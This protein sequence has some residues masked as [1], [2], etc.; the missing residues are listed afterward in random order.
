MIQHGSDQA[1][2][3]LR[4]LPQPAPLAAAVWQKVRPA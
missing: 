3:S 4:T 2:H 1:R